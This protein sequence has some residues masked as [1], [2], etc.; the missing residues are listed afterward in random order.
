M[1]KPNPLAKLY[2][3]LN[4]ARLSDTLPKTPEPPKI[5]L[6]SP[7]ISVKRES[8]VKSEKSENKPKPKVTIVEPEPPKEIVV[9][10]PVAPVKIE[11]QPPVIESSSDSSES[12]PEPEPEVKQSVSQKV[13]SK[14]STEEGF[15][16]DTVVPL[17]KAKITRNRAKPEP[18]PEPERES[19]IPKKGERGLQSKYSFDQRKQIY[20]ERLSRKSVKLAEKEVSAVNEV[21]E[22]NEH[23]PERLKD[24]ERQLKRKLKL[25]N[26]AKFFTCSDGKPSSLQDTMGS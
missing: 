8:S 5:S 6:P 10:K 24:D 16:G 11:S 3:H 13:E 23:N 1:L 9:K 21:L 14:L 15:K 20:L 7:P 25:I 19:Q 2:P 22:R 18:K 12:E 4:F 17:P 26:Y